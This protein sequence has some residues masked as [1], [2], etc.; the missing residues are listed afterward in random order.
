MYFRLINLAVILGAL[1]HH[2]DALTRGEMPTC[3]EQVVVRLRN[4]EIEPT[5]KLILDRAFPPGVTEHDY[6]KW[7]D[8]HELTEPHCQ[9]HTDRLSMALDDLEC[10]WNFVESPE[11]DDE[12]SNALLTST[13]QHTQFFVLGAAMC[14]AAEED[15]QASE[16]MQSH[17]E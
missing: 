4:V 3:I 1:A 9:E 14:A 16:R 2:G 13:D 6:D 5:I 8:T 15:H 12:Y 7:V 10:H 11:F 17:A